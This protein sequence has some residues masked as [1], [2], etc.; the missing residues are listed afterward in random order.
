MASEISILVLKEEGIGNGI[1]ATPMIRALRNKFPNGRIDL[2]ASDRNFAVL[3]GLTSVNNIYLYGKQPIP[4]KYE[5]GIATEFSTG[6]FRRTANPICNNV[7]ACKERNFQKWHEATHNLMIVKQ[8]FNA[9]EPGEFIPTEIFIS[10]ADRI[11]AEC[12]VKQIEKPFIVIHQGCLST[13]VWRNRRWVIDRWVELIKL[14]TSEFGVAVVC[15]GAE[16]E[17][18]DTDYLKQR[19]PVVDMVQKTTIKQSAA[20]TEKAKMLISIDCGMMHVA[21]A[22]GTPQIALFG[23]TS[24]IKS[25]PW[26]NDGKFV[27]IR[28]EVECQRCYINNPQLFQYCDDGKCMTGITTEQVF[29]KIKDLKWLSD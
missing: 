10:E 2:L 23:C 18:R 13:D 6:L 14:L 22:V 9:W 28:H 11:Y 3:E 19:V 20:I 1:L 17:R 29:T 8:H 21:A 26:R 7:L 16:S 4:I 25:S 12:I 27:I 5:F 15:V 24:E